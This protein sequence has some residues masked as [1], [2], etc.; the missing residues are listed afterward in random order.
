MEDVEAFL[1]AWDTFLVPLSTGW[2]DDVHTY[3]AKDEQPY[4]Q[5]MMGYNAQI[6]NNLNNFLYLEREQG[7]GINE[8]IRDG[9]LAIEAGEL[10]MRGADE[11][12][13]WDW[14]KIK[15]IDVAAALEK[16]KRLIAL[17]DER[18]YH[19]P[20]VGNFVNAT[21]QLKKCPGCRANVPVCGGYQNFDTAA[22]PDEPC[23]QCGH[24]KGCHKDSIDERNAFLKAGRYGTTGSGGRHDSHQHR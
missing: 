10:L 6:Q 24:I 1:A 21:E 11:F 3:I 16:R 20:V 9:S 18:G 4:I 2:G 7:R 8:M 22:T 5:A 14:H 19:R 23:H 12:G 17:A 13:D 15:P